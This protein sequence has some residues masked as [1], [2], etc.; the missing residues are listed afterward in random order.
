MLLHKDVV[1][2]EYVGQG[3]VLQVDLVEP[4]VVDVGDHHPVRRDLDRADLL[5]EGLAEVSHAPALG[6]RHLVLRRHSALV[7]EN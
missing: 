4:V 2:L 1:S 5:G 3:V 6:A 7:H